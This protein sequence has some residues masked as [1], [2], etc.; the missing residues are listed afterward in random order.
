VLIGKAIIG[1]KTH[2]PGDLA[3]L[4]SAMYHVAPSKSIHP[5]EVEEALLDQ[6]AEL[7]VDIKFSMLPPASM[8]APRQATANGGAAAAA[9]VPSPSGR[10][11]VAPAVPYVDRGDPFAVIVPEPEPVPSARRIED[12]TARLAALKARLEADPRPRYVVNKDRMDHGPFT[13]VELLQQIA[14]NTFTSE[15]ILR[16]EISGQ[17]VPIAE[18]EEFAPFAQHTALK[19]E[20]VAERKAVVAAERFEKKSGIAKFVVGSLLVVALGTGATLWFLKHKGTR[21]DGEVSVM[22]DSY[23]GVDVKGSLQGKARGPGGGTGRRGTGPGGPGQ[24]GQPGFSGGTSFENVLDNNNQSIT[25]GQDP[26]APDLTNAQ[27]AAPLRSAGFI[28]G[29]GAPD[30]MKVTVRVAVKMGRA[31]GVTVGTNPASPGVAACVDRHVRGIAWPVSAKTDF[32][33]TVY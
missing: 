19:R 9:P 6:S 4:A 17:A 27:L 3:A 13:A 1:D 21:R 26:G 33:T 30:D 16:D 8:H 24:P 20:I 2:R 5:P 10:L 31:V 29:C 22:D 7:E 25:M 15:H 18:W 11:P 28:S 23:A 12:P 14:S 32:V